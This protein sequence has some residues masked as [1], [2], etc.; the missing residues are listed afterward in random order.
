MGSTGARRGNADNTDA[1]SSVAFTDVAGKGGQRI[2]ARKMRV[3]L[4]DS[5]GLPAVPGRPTIITTTSVSGL[6]GL[7]STQRVSEFT[8]IAGAAVEIHPSW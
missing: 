6:G 3:L 7:S 1:P 5:Y 2:A 4:H 8:E